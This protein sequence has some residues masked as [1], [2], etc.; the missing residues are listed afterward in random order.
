[1]IINKVLTFWHAFVPNKLF[2]I[3]LKSSPTNFIFLKSFNSKF[4][5]TQVWL[6]D[7]NGQTLEI[8]GKQI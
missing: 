1:M 5:E 4:Q 7:Q 3:S 6:T 8:E 2:G